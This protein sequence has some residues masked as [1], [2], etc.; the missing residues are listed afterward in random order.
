MQ[1]QTPLDDVLETQAHVRVLRALTELPRGFSASAR[2][3]ARRSGVAHTT[4]A[5]VLRTL[6]EQRVVRT[7]HVGRAYLFRLNETHVLVAQIRALFE[8]EARL[9][10]RLID[11][12]RAELPRRVGRAEGAFLFGSASRGE[13]RAGS[14]IDVALVAPE[15]S[16]EDLEPALTALSD[17]VRSRFGTE[18]NVVVAPRGRQRRNEARLWRRIEMEGV[19]LLGPSAKRG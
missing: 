18:L 8:S 11:Y 7:Q 19:P 9:R 3:L 1:L 5:R 2:D 14:D 12:L 16:E 17:A 15:R 4:A 6:A 13:T 10:T